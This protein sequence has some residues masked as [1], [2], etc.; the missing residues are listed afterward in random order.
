VEN[1][2][3]LG[4]VWSTDTHDLASP[5]ASL[6]EAG[7]GTIDH[8]P[9][10]SVPEGPF[11]EPLDEGR[12]VAELICSSEDEGSERGFGDVDADV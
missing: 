4:D 8:V 7:G 3:V 2:R 12:L 10:L 9:K 11:G 5:K 6:D 1:D